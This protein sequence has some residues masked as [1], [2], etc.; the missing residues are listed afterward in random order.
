MSQ[1]TPIDIVFP[2]DADQRPISKDVFHVPRIGEAI[3]VDKMVWRITDIRHT[4]RRGSMLSPRA[5]LI[6]AYE[7]EV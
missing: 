6:V 2:K 7:G 5:R 4:F 1:F 3:V